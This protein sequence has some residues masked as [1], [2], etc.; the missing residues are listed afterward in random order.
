MKEVT[1]DDFKIKVTSSKCPLPRFSITVE[2]YSPEP[3]G[4]VV[5]VLAFK[6]PPSK[7]IYSREQRAVTLRIFNRMIGIYENGLITFCA[8][9]LEE[10]KSVLEKIKRVMEE[11]Q[12]EALAKGIP[13][14]ADLEKW[15]RLNPLE[16][17]NHLP[18]A[19]CGE[20]GEETCIAFAAK[21]LS[22]GKKLRDC[23]LLR[24][25][26]YNSLIEEM[27]KKYGNRIVG[28]LGWR[29]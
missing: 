27:V 24:Q 19:N 3:L 11:A 16:L 6:F 8:E 1:I 20:C 22:G 4:D 13:D 2:V 12:K 10:A 7:A 17:Y 29:F 9:N 21:V 26:K 5:R 15:N 18:K 14:I 23:N 28:A 25:R